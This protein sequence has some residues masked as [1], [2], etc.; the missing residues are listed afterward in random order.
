MIILMLEKKASINLDKL[1]SSI[2]KFGIEFDLI[3]SKAT[4]TTT[5]MMWRKWKKKKQIQNISAGS[6]T[7]L[8]WK[9]IIF[10]KIDEKYNSYA[11]Y[12]KQVIKYSRKK[13]NVS[14]SSECIKNSN[15]I[16]WSNKKKKERESNT[17]TMETKNTQNE[18][19]KVKIQLWLCMTFFFRFA[20]QFIEMYIQTFCS[21][22][23]I[24]SPFAHCYVAV[25]FFFFFV[26]CPIPWKSIDPC[27]ALSFT[28][29]H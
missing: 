15:K 1:N 10:S 14:I 26:C 28:F 29:V 25:V 4:T 24:F 19:N 6:A 5:K 18:K 11:I 8:K 9:K 27:I 17:F 16:F 7:T 20:S 21:C 13:E 2:P 22:L 23:Q 3:G 12:R